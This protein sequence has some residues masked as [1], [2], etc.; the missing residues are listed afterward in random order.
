ME[1]FNFNTK[2][3]TELAPIT[4]LQE[5][6]GASGDGLTTLMVF[7]FHCVNEMMGVKD[8][9]FASLLLFYSPKRKQ[10]LTLLSNK[11]HLTTD[12]SLLT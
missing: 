10:I 4:G 11:G 5:E 8:L 6:A 12:F 7:A 9:P 2:H 3:R 1:Q